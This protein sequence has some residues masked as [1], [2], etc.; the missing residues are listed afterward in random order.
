MQLKKKKSTSPPLQNVKIFLFPEV[1]EVVAYYNKNFLVLNTMEDVP[2]CEIK[3]NEGTGKFHA[4]K[5]SI[6]SIS[7][8]ISVKF[9]YK[10]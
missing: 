6:S 7:Q 10:K 9:R 3:Q 5:E 2:I 8:D 4:T 1:L